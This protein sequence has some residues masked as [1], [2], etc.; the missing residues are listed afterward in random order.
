MIKSSQY[1]TQKLE[2]MRQAILNSSSPFTVDQA[3]ILQHRFF[4]EHKWSVFQ[5]CAKL[6]MCPARFYIEQNL[7]LEKCKRFISTAKL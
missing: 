6:Y 1:D 3:F 2:E 7:A 5:I 4:I